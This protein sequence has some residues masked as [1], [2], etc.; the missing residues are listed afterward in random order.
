PL[1]IAN[2]SLEALE[3]NP[4]EDE[5]KEML[6]A[7]NAALDQMNAIVKDLITVSEYGPGWKNDSWNSVNLAALIKKIA[8]AHEKAIAGKHIVFSESHDDAAS[9]I[10]ANEVALVAVFENLFDNAVTYTPE[11]GRIEA[12]L[13]LQDG[14]AHFALKD[15]GI[16]IT[17][18]DKKSI[19]LQFFRATNSVSMKN[20][21][22]GLGLY[23]CKNIIDGL[24]G[25]IWFE[26][27]ENEGTAVHFTVPIAY[28]GDKEGLVVPA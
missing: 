27:K 13:T 17:E 14:N 1:S 23:I 22:T 19:F 12:S 4:T 6:T 5:K 10:Q 28:K 9:I 8:G 18:S 11:N 25:R 15:S 2:W 20:V 16:G 3:G 7:L 24:G 21:G 26:S